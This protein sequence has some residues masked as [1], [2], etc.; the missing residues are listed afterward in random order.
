MIPI[1]RHVQKFSV[2]VI[3]QQRERPYQIE[4]PARTPKQAVETMQDGGAREAGY[5]DWVEISCQNESVD[6]PP[7]PGGPRRD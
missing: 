3:T 6:R 7:H 2:E 1:Q 4:V 5:Y